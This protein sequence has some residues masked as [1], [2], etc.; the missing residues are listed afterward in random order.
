LKKFVLVMMILV[1]LVGTVL[2]ACAEEAE[3]PAP[4]PAPAPREPEQPGK[5]VVIEPKIPERPAKPPEVEPEK[6]Y[7]LKYS[8]WG[9]P[10]ID[11]GVR[12][13]EWIQVL[14]E[15][16]DGRLVVD[17]YWSESLLRRPDTIRGCEAGLADIVL[18]VLGAC[19]GVHNINRV[20][21]LPGTGM[22]GQIAMHH[23]Y[24]AL[25]EKYP[26][27]EE[28]Y[29]KTNTFPL[30]MRGLPAEHIH[31]T[32]KFHLVKTPEDI[33]GLK[34]YA[35]A[36]WADQFDK[37]GA[38]AMQPAVMEWYT[39]LERNLIQGFFIHWLSIYSFGLTELCK[40]HSICGEGGTGMQTFGY[41]MNRDSFEQ[42]PADLQKI[43]LDT[44]DEWMWY[45]LNEDDP[46]TIAAGEAYAKE[47]GNEVYYMTEAE[48]QAWVDFAQPIHEQWIAD[49]E[50]EGYDN[51]R[52]IYNDM[53]DLIETWKE[54]G[55]LD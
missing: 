31:T 20:I 16:S 19:P 8:D 32:D 46:A 49:R 45:S 52:D 54:K 15:R 23:I 10:F 42:L 50:K 21:D 12:A 28:E 25:Y 38:A 2:S 24:N 33:A 37:M 3:E 29:T 53:M 30:F 5:Y 27:F 14:Y 34:T 40:Y 7:K 48:Q 55:S 11:L 43:F 22:P 26:E 6:V 13:K 35:N 1:L 41:I 9:P 44:Q 4:A 18:Y 47:L 39:S 17:G 51:A 36:L